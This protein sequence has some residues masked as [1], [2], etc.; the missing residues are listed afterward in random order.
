MV[1]QNINDVLLLSDYGIY[2]MKMLVF[3]CS[4][5]GMSVGMRNCILFHVITNDELDM[6]E[7]SIY[8]IELSL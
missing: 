3:M 8:K 5:S 2:R 1:T 6:I 4:M 7:I